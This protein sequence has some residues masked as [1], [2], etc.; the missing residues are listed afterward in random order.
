MK[1]LNRSDSIWGALVLM[2][3]ANSAG[4]ASA[5]PT[6]ITLPGAG[7]FPE[8]ITS[9]AD[10]TLIIGS[11]GKGNIL[12]ITPGKT[13]ADEWIRPGTGGLNDELGV[14]ADEKGKQLWV[15]LNNLENKGEATAATGRRRSGPESLEANTVTNLSTSVS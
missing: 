2:T 8:S 1:L 4:A 11:L 14:F 15:C 13:T 10:G 12:R 9:T 7:V 6:E 5:G 3:L